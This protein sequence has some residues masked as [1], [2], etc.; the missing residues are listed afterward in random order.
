[1]N[2]VKKVDV[3]RP[4]ITVMASDLPI[5]VDVEEN[6]ANGRRANIVVIAVISIGLSLTFPPSIIACLILS[7]FIIFCLILVSRTIAFVT[8]IPI[9]ISIPINDGRSSVESVMNSATRTPI[10]VTGREKRIAIGSIIDEKVAIIITRTMNTDIPIASK[11]ELNED[12]C[13]DED[14]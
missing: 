6:S 11:R 3:K 2:R 14:P 12:A 10:M 8:T 5:R 9:S 7:P 4:P 1:M 13:S